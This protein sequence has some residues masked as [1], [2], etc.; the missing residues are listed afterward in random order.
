MVSASYLV[1][2]FSGILSC[3]LKSAGSLLMEC[4]DGILLFVEKGH[5]FFEIVFQSVYCLF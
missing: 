3:F 4:V 2:R 1:G 5:W